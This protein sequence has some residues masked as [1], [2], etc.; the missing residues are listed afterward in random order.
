MARKPR[1]LPEG[2]TPEVTTSDTPKVVVT[3]VAAEA[4]AAPVLSA[5]TLA[6]MEMGRAILEG[7]VPRAASE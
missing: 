1:I 4:P 3:E 5:Q 6:E 7:R 2:V